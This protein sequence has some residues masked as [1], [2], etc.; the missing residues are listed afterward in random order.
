MPRAAPAP[1]C[2]HQRWQGHGEG[3]AGGAQQQQRGAEL[4]CSPAVPPTPLADRGTPRALPRAANVRTSCTSAK[5]VPVDIQNANSP[6]VSEGGRQCPCR[7]SHPICAGFWL[8]LLQAPATFP[9]RSLQVT[10]HSSP[11]GLFSPLGK[12]NCPY[13]FCPNARSLQAPLEVWDRKPSLLQVSARTSI[14]AQQTLNQEIKINCLGVRPPALSEQHTSCPQTQMCF[15][16]FPINHSS[17]GASQGALVLG[18]SQC[19]CPRPAGLVATGV[20]KGSSGGGGRAQGTLSDL[21]FRA[22][23][24]K[25]VWGGFGARSR[26]FPRAGGRWV[27]ALVRAAWKGPGCGAPGAAGLWAGLAAGKAGQNA[28]VLLHGGLLKN[29]RLCAL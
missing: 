28:L 23:F 18:C 26:L 20:G 2:G 22:G 10:T 16:I 24:S 19:C 6:G 15:S 5:N 9:A 3:G 14:P 11:R 27:P 4:C 21:I 13:L 7:G 12:E 25:L 17:F 29:S 8:L 1:R